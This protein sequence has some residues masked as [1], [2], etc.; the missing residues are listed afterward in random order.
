[1]NGKKAKRIRRHSQVLLVSWLKTLLSE[2]EAENVTVAN[3][4][5]MMPEQTH[6]FVQDK[7]LLNAY[8]PKWI[9]KKIN[10]LTA[11]YSDLKI[12]DVNL[13]LI[14][15]KANKLQGG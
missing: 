12:E 1:M 9:V 10:Q 13:E 15:W 7:F 4:K 2:E 3:Y 6:A 5:Q 11:I 14:Q 8:H